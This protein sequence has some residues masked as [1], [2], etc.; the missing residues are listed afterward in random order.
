M[1]WYQKIKTNI[2]SLVIWAEQNLKGKTGAEKKAAV[3]DALCQNINLPGPLNWFKRPII[4]FIVGLTLDKICET[5]NIVTDHEGFD[6]VVVDPAG[7]V[8]VSSLPSDTVARSQNITAMSKQQ[9]VD[10][11]L[12]ALYA[13]YGIE[14]E[15][16]ADVETPKVEAIT[17]T[18]I[19][20]GGDHFS[21]SEFACKCGCGTNKVKQELIDLL[22]D[23]S[24]DIDAREGKGKHLPV[25]V[26]SGT[27]C[28]KRNAACGG[29]ANSLHLTGEAADIQ[30]KSVSASNVWSRIRGMWQAGKLALMRGLGRYDTF[31]HVE[32]GKK[33]ADGSLYEWDY[34]GKK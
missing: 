22:N 6:D 21:R 32:I 11:R 34:R 23:I 14:A 13:Q 29:S 17:T 27:R 8:A 10:E 26:T 3:V 24:D 31:T 9:T 1:S 2:A 30:V 19:K 5:L 28:A 15:T 20:T 25:I 7:V 18:P 33:K 16:S 4:K 12:A